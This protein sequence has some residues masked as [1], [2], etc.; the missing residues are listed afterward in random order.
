MIAVVPKEDVKD[1][2]GILTSYLAELAGSD[3][4]CVYK[5]ACKGHAQIWLVHK[6]VD[7][8]ALFITTVNSHAGL[9]RVELHYVAGRCRRKDLRAI[10]EALTSF[11]KWVKADLIILKTEHKF[12]RAL[13]STGWKYNS[14][15]YW[16]RT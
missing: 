2:K 10:D 8:S 12:K 3:L 9:R 7:I 1:M 13:E 11:R 5:L 14:D 4:S 15:N 6:D 16:W